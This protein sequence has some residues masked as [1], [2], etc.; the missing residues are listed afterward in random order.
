MDDTS[1]INA[2]FN[3]TSFDFLTAFVTSNVTVPVLGFGI[4]PF[5]PNTR[6]S[7]PTSPIMSGVATITSKSNQPCWILLM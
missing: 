5:G 1:F 3:F 7:L 6:P 4:K 2:V